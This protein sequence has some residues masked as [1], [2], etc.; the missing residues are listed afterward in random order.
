MHSL[1]SDR[2]VIRKYAPDSTIRHFSSLDNKTLVLPRTKSMVYHLVRAC[3]NAIGHVVRL[4]TPHF[5]RRKGG[6]WSK[7]VPFG[8]GH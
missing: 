8:G 1:Y 2:L 3:H 6:M 4:S 7:G 5:H